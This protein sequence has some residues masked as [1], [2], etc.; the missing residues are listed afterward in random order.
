MLSYSASYCG[1]TL[2]AENSDSVE[3]HICGFV[4]NK[5][6]QTT[7]DD[8]DG[9]SLNSPISKFLSASSPPLGLWSATWTGMYFE[10]LLPFVRIGSIDSSSQSSSLP[11]PSSKPRSRART[12][13]TQP[14]LSTRKWKYT[15][16]GKLGRKKNR[17]HRIGQLGMISRGLFSA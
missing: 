7:F 11:V 10:P 2:V 5:Q 17:K 8:E 15:T 9:L 12:D 4:R 1:H 6:H 14:S 16:V 3:R 13:W